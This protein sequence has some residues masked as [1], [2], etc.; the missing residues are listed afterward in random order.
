MSKKYF[1]A[2]GAPP[3]HHPNKG[4]WFGTFWNTI[5]ARTIL[6]SRIDRLPVYFRP[7]V[8]LSSF[9]YPY[10]KL[11][12]TRLSSSTA[13]TTLLPWF[14]LSLCH[15]S[16]SLLNI[17]AHHVSHLGIGCHRSSF[18]HSFIQLAR[19]HCVPLESWPSY[20]LLCSSYA[21]KP[22]FP[23]LPPSPCVVIRVAVLAWL[24]RAGRIAN[25]RG[26]KTSCRSPNG[27]R[28]SP[29]SPPPPQPS[30]IEVT[31]SQHYIL[32]ERKSVNRVSGSSEPILFRRHH[33]SSRIFPLSSRSTLSQLALEI[34][35][36]PVCTSLSD[37]SHSFV[38]LE[39]G[40]KRRGSGWIILLPL[41]G[42]GRAMVFPVF[43]CSI[44]TFQIEIALFRIMRHNEC[45]LGS[46]DLT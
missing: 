3:G 19:W 26:R 5:R 10:G 36:L 4:N 2:F 42:N 1:I 21:P 27:L 22:L 20:F 28:S 12:W 14:C 44:V 17:I 30:F 38:P 16:L 18:I 29:S 11:T 31:K 23:S 32:R 34:G 7:L 46:Y 25:A 37:I 8:S 45:P 15:S 41:L 33:S 24:I 40:H 6:R 35:V 13:P 39:T 43:T 9:F